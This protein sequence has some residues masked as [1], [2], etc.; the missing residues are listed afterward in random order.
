MGFG[1]LG[2]EVP[3]SVRPQRPFYICQNCTAYNARF[4]KE[5]WRCNADL[6]KGAIEPK[7][8]MGFRL[9]RLATKKQSKPEGK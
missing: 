4:L 6:T 3:M 9:E 7:G 8:E 5:C 2:L 1:G